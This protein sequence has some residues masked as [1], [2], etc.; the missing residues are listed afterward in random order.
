VGKIAG[1]ASSSPT[2]SRALTERAIN[3]PQAMKARKAEAMI[4]EMMPARTWLTC[5]EVS[6]LIGAGDD[7]KTRARLDH[8]ARDGK[9]ECKR[10][11]GIRGLVYLFCRVP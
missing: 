5:T 2:R 4:L 10:E 7:R 1:R 9:I 8:L 3:A 6:R 11:V